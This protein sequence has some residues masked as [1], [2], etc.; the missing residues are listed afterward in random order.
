MKKTILLLASALVLWSCTEGGLPLVETD[1]NAIQVVMESDGTK[2]SVTDMGY[3]TWSTGDRIWLHTTSG[4]VEG[5]LSAGA[6]TVNATFTYGPYV[7]TMTGMGVYPYGSHAITEGQLT[8]NLPATYELGANT[9]NTN[10]A[11]CG[12]AE[13]GILKFNH[14]AGV[15]K[16]TFNNAP[17]GTSQF[18]L[19]LDRKINGDFQ[20][21]LTAIDPVISTEEAT[22][23]SQRTVIFNFNPLQEAKSLQLYIPL[24]IG[25]YNSLAI[26][27]SAGEERVWSYSNAVTNTINR[28]TLLLMPT[29]TLGGTVNGDIEHGDVSGG[30]VEDGSDNSDNSGNAIDY[31]DEY[32]INHGHGVEIDAVVWA[33]VNCGYHA[34]DYPWGKLYQWGRK[35]GQGYSHDYDATEPVVK[36]GNRVSATVGNDVANSNIFYKVQYYYDWVDPWDGTLWN[37]GTESEPVKTDYDPCPDGWR[38]PTYAELDMLYLNHSSWTN[39]DAFQSGYWFCGTSKYSEDTPRIFLAAAGNRANSDGFAHYRKFNGYYWSS[40]DGNGDSHCLNFSD[41]GIYIALGHRA[42]AYSVRCVQE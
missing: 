17:A 40:D 7:G 10:A 16:F 8:V 23:D 6:G 36:D 42:Y 9:Y 30:D 31:V 15:M 24:P 38:V 2:T 32:G 41:S 25:T 33:P 19:T 20:A 28:K 21:D 35:Y 4:S 27:L 34:T 39:N 37:L 1:V 22:D 5:V 29:I 26:E 3:F 13:N 14:L 18:K 12:E 11:M